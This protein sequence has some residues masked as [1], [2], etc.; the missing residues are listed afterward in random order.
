MSR[1]KKHICKKCGAEIPY[2]WMASGAS[3]V[4]V[5]YDLGNSGTGIVTTYTC[6]SCRKAIQVKS[7]EVA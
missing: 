5:T 3:R 4:Q 7:V 2:H 6:N 1:R